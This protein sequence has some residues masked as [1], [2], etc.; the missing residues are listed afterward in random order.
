M[1]Q[2]FLHP[3]GYPSININPCYQINME[4]FFILLLEGT[5]TETSDLIPV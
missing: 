4:V 5:P 3:Y 2:K 1:T